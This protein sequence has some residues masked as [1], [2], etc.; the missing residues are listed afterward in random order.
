MPTSCQVVVPRFTETRR[1]RRHSSRTRTAIY[2][3]WAAV[4]LTPS[5]GLCVDPVIPPINAGDM[6]RNTRNL[7]Q[8]QRANALMA[9]K[10][11]YPPEWRI[12]PDDRS[13]INVSSVQIRGNHQIPTTELMT[14]LQPHIGQT[15]QLGHIK[16]LTDALAQRYA[17]AEIPVRVYFPV[18]KFPS[19]TLIIQIIELKPTQR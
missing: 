5:V 2:C 10:D 15:K 3:L 11:I 18:Q 7:E 12:A 1:H 19:P 13:E 9:Q 17:E 14:V 6:M 16:S 4:S 8:T